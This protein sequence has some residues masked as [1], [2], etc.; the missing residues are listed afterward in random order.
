MGRV[1]HWTADQARNDQS[2]CGMFVENSWQ[3]P[4]GFERCTNSRQCVR[5]YLC[6]NGF[7]DCDLGTDEDHAFCG[8]SVTHSH[9]SAW[10]VLTA[11]P[12]P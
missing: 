3:C 5:D 11:S 8:Q 2:G 10:P 12:S 6:C 7:N 4:G 9:T 1:N